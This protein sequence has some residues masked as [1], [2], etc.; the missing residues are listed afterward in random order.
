[1]RL[2][3]R[4]LLIGAGVAVLL[5]G[6]YAL[7]GFVVVPHLL[8]SNVTQFV[9]T[10]YHR[11]LTLGQIRFNPFLLTLDV[12]DIS[13]P[14]ADAQPLLSLR[15]LFVD[16]QFSSIW[17]RGPVFR[18]ILLERPF[19]RAV[20][21]PDGALNLM[22]LAKPFAEPQA[23]P[24][25]KSAP[26][27]LFIR[28]LTVID[29]R[30]NFEDRTHVSPFRA[31]LL[32]I[33]F[34]L[35]D[36]ATTGSAADA[37]TLDFS[38]P[39]GEGVHWSGTLGVA[40]FGSRGRFAIT[41][42]RART[43]WNY[44]RDA[45]HFEVSSGVI[46]LS[47]EYELTTAT[48]P[49]GLTLNVS[50]LSVDELGVRPA[51]SDTDY[52]K[53]KHIEVN[54]TRFDLARR[55]IDI[56]AVQLAGGT[57]SAWRNADGTLNFAA[58]TSQTPGSTPPA[59]SASATPTASASATPTPSASGTSTPPTGSAPAGTPASAPA[60]GSSTWSVSV[61]D[62]EVSGLDL[63]AEDRAVMPAATLALQRISLRLKGLHMPA[64]DPLN[65]SIEA[66]VNG[67][68][69]L[70]GTGTYDLSS[71]AAHAH[72]ELAQLDLT[73]LQPYVAQYTSLELLSGAFSTKLDIERTASGDLSAAGNTQVAK[74]RLVDDELR[75]DFVK[76]DQ[77]SIEGMRYRT[78]PARLDIQ[79]IVARAPYARVIIAPDRT[80]NI[81]EAFSPAGAQKA[82]GKTSTAQPPKTVPVA[83]K[84]PDST[85]ARATSHGSQSASSSAPTMAMTIGTVQ[86]VNGA[87]HYTDLWIKPRFSVAIQE[88][89]GTIHGLSSDAHSR[90]K[91][92]LNGKVD[93]Y[94][95]VHIWGELNLLSASLYTD[96]KMS[97]HGVELTTIT[98]YSA[99]FAGY[100][101]EKGKLSVDLS[102][103]IE[104][105]QLNADH[106]FV[107]EQLQLGDKV[108]SPDAVKLPLKL[109]VALL[110]DRNGVIDVPLPVTGS[111]DDP[112]FRVGPIIWKAVVNLLVKVATAPFA[113]LGK[114]FGGGEQMN[115]IEFDAGSAALDATAQER[116]Q[117]V[118]KSLQERP[119]LELDVPSAYS[120]DLDGPALRKSLLEQKLN[121][122]AGKQPA[123]NQ[124][125]PAAGNATATDPAARF[126]LLLAE[127]RAELGAGTTFPALSQ[128]IVSTKPK[129]GQAPPDFEAAN[130][131]L[132]DLLTARTQV[133]E[134]DLV[135]LGQHRAR[136]IQQVL[137]DGTQI[138]AARVFVINTPPR[139]PQGNRVQVE[140][141]LK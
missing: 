71:S 15:R 72:V 18:E 56:A 116:L 109:A 6:G 55:T 129:K 2:P 29:G 30:T 37:Y 24:Q 90:A 9:S 87:A 114:L 91:V 59:T 80:L 31:E 77:L 139:P 74:L 99:H 5:V 7:A 8:R 34:D 130:A 51:H 86:I 40:P 108:D 93:R 81:A 47:G 82:T 89:A 22:D 11:K 134:G 67:S 73:A 39:L 85:A 104:N 83:Q 121:A 128:A 136:A 28:R 120:P 65:L 123:R 133:G 103:H 69:K 60:Q 16:L 44:A 132:E 64:K 13:F 54:G 57:L 32:P 115:Q 61:P 50:T 106:H 66:A 49:V 140:L 92:E 42:L 26:M 126:Q 41:A 105:R 21:R 35:R 113:L 1:M 79:R 125:T 4:R 12:R 58:L 101:I 111:L 68:G 63:S 48:T 84:D 122:R 94:A 33:N 19:V 98:P 137:L 124:S 102:Y 53:L 119:H 36:F 23:P 107:I 17:H 3:V 70:S 88:L 135:S 117:G 141:S 14:D 43:L 118:V 131:E 112:Q 25:P 127:Y 27:R 100:K 46:G 38:T 76:W 10:H 62:I 78:Q 96:M 138:D 75:Q 45:L 97:F 95:P 20:L 110:K 52:I